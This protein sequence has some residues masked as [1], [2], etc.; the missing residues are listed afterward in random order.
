VPN[1]GRKKKLKQNTASTEA[2]SAGPLSI[3]AAMKSTARRSA[4]ATVVEL[5]CPPSSLSAAVSAAT[6][7]AAIR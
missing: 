2:T 5:T 3:R 4:S 1:G 6:T 7:A